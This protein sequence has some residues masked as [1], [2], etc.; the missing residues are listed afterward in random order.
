MTQTRTTDPLSQ[1]GLAPRP[2]EPQVC[3]RSAAPS[4]R[5][6]RDI[7]WYGIPGSV[8]PGGVSPHHPAVPLPGVR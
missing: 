7:T 4:T 6:Q 1:T 8:W 5:T 3:S 2:P